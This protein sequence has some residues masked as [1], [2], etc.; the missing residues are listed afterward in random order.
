MT[1]LG[2]KGDKLFDGTWG[3]D[4]GFRY[5]QIRDSA[6]GNFVSGL[7]FDRIL[8]ANDPIFDPELESVHR[9]NYPI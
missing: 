6:T 5:S 1:T 9:H 7:L 4:L 2:L 3:Y 8:N